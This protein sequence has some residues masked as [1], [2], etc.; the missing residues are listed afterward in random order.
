MTIDEK[1]VLRYDEER[2]KYCQ[3]EIDTAKERIKIIRYRENDYKNRYAKSTVALIILTAI[4]IVSVIALINLWS[5]PDERGRLHFAGPHDL[6]SGSVGT[7]I[8]FVCY[9]FFILDVISLVWH[10]NNC[11]NKKYFFSRHDVQTKTYAQLY[12]E[13]TSYIAKMHEEYLVAISNYEA[14]RQRLMVDNVEKREREGDEH[15]DISELLEQKDKT[16]EDGKAYFDDFF[17]DLSDKGRQKKIIG[18][19]TKR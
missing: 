1:S 10:I 5:I 6:V 18:V 3:K 16:P 4:L 19:I 9:G 8:Y 11:K 13:E 17:I 7:G 12:A 14:D 15:I 2:I